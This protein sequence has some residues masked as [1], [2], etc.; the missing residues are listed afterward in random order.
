MLAKDGITANYATFSIDKIIAGLE[1]LKNFVNGTL[2]SYED[3]Y[4]SRSLGIKNDLGKFRKEEITVGDLMLKLDEVRVATGG[5]N[6]DFFNTE[7]PEEIASQ[8]V[9]KSETEEISTV[10]TEELAQE[11]KDVI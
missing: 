8:G 6:E 4:L 9:E 5:K 2:R 7:T 1:G 10:D 3:E 11:E